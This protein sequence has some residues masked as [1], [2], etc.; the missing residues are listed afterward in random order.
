MLTPK[1]SME[2]RAVSRHY[3]SATTAT[4]WGRAHSPFSPVNWS[5][6]L[7]RSFLRHS[8]L[9]AYSRDGIKPLRCA[10]TP[11]SSEEDAAVVA[12]ESGASGYTVLEHLFDA[13]LEHA[14]LY[15]LGGES[16][17]IKKTGRVPTPV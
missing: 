3:S 6:E 5:G 12:T 13:M 2:G 9:V 16:P 4:L 10:P 17:L 8:S 7:H 1:R 15:S 11:G 14:W